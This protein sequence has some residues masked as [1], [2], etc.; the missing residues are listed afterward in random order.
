M[1]ELKKIGQEGIAIL[2]TTGC[3]KDLVDLPMVGVGSG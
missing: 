3:K 1:L 2:K